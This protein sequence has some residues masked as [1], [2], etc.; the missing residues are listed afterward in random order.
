MKAFPVWLILA[1]RAVYAQQ[2]AFEVA[3][4]RP[5]P[6]PLNRIADY[7]ASGPRLSLGGYSIFLLVLEAYNLRN[8]QVAVASP[9]LP[10]DDY[11]DITA[12]AA[13]TRAPTRD[14]FRQMLQ[15]L[16]ADRFNLKVHREMREMPVYA[17]IV[18]KS[19]SKL[20][21][22]SGDGACASRIGPLQPQDRNYRYQYTNCT[23][24]PLVNTLQLDRP[25]LDKTGL[26]GRYDISIFATPD[27]K[28]RNSSEP[29]D[30]SPA[31]AVREFGLKLEPQ[32]AMIEMLVV[33]AVEKPT[34]N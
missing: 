32:K 2:P 31:D 17:L 14:E 13:G 7:S 26:A 27:F 6:A 18:D 12:S 3:S 10:L 34:G 33:D 20:K 9:G 5:H 8:F 16:L 1:S 29:G 28:L 30:I 11:Y 22:G 4:I 25:I 23:L 24:E 15:S 19:G 21:P